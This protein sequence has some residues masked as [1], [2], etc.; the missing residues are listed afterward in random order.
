MKS[1]I[2]FCNLTAL[3]KNLTRFAPAWVLYGVF[4][5][6]ILIMVLDS[7]GTGVW[8]AHSMAESLQFTPFVNMA[9]AFLCAQLLFG[10]LYNSRMCNALHAMPMRRETWFCTNVLSGIL[11]SLIP[12]FVIMLLSSLFMESGIVMAP[13][14]LLGMTLQFLFFFGVAVFSAYSVGNRFA[15]ALV[16]II[17]N[18]FSMIAYWLLD[19]LYA[20][21]LYGIRIDETPFTWFCPIFY[22]ISTPAVLY[23]FT[24]HGIYVVNGPFI[25]LEEGFW[26]TGICAAI[27]IGFMA[28]ALLLYRKRNLECAGDFVSVKAFAPVFLVLYCLCGGAVCYMFFSLFVG[29]ESL[30]FLLVGMLIGWFTGRML[31]ERT[32]RVFRLK[33]FIGCGILLL[34]LFGSLLL[35]ALD[36]LGITR[37]VPKANAVNGVHIV[38][39]GSRYDYYK[40]G[41]NYLDSAEDIETVLALHRYGIN[42]RDADYNGELDVALTIDYTLKSGVTT[43]RNYVIDVNT[44]EGQALEKILS[45]PQIVLG[46]E[47][48]DAKSFA[49]TLVLM[50]CESD[51]AIVGDRMVE[52]IDAIIKDCNEGN[53]AQDWNFHND[54]ATTIWLSMQLKSDTDYHQYRDIRVF[55]TCTHTM[56]Y[57]KEHDLLPDHSIYK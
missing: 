54:E 34:V 15:M 52:L 55:R 16:Y 40:E 28:L 19:S 6:L 44:P 2:S 23:E 22:M 57:L 37:W 3:K 42:H 45:R 5:L 49:E 30:F 46:T 21:Q 24:S 36:P 43:S 48:T 10:D 51:G 8:F 4:W 9:Y 13:L 20:P 12:N 31:L 38:T 1:K 25:Y 11:F 35:T 17:I 27:G 14:W 47:V 26:Y 32:V 53:M 56:N 41:S 29:E 33:S 7:E 50:R 39:G 18:G